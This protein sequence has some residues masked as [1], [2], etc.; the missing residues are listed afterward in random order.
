M[1]RTDPPVRLRAYQE[2]LDRADRIKDHADA[3]CKSASTALVFFVIGGAIGELSGGDSN[4]WLR[5]VPALIAAAAYATPGVLFVVDRYKYK[6]AIAA[7]RAAEEWLSM[8]TAPRDGTVILGWYG[9]DEQQRIRWAEERHCVLSSTAPGAGLF[10]PGWEDEVEGL[11][12]EDPLS[13]KPVDG[14]RPPS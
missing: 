7:E 8:D 6:K 13:W 3:L 12:V 11:N 9:P 5:L 14:Q 10:G 2:W 1:P 4:L